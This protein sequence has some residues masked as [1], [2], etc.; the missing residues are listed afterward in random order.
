MSA[1]PWSRLAAPF[2]SAALA[3]HAVGASGDGTR[4][5]MSP[6]LPSVFLRERLD[7]VVGP[8]AWSLKL[9]PWSDGGIVAELTIAGATR[10][11]AVG[12]RPAPT[13][14]AAG[15]WIDVAAGAGEA[16]FAAAAAGF[17][18]L[19]PVEGSDDGWVDA[20]PDTGEPLFVPAT[21]PRTGGDGS[22]AAGADPGPAV[23]A[24]TLADDD[25]NG[26]DRADDPAVAAEVAPA[27]VRGNEPGEV[28]RE[29][30]GKPEAHRM[31]DRL[32]ERL[33]EEGLGAE[34]ARLVLSY[35]GYGKDQEHSRELYA[36][37]RAL[38]IGRGAH[39]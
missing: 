5:R 22:L 8:A 6:H 29:T 18:M 26:P 38:L 32:V 15:G 4:L 30:A 28:A 23:A 39:A 1:D 19:P 35:G 16:A 11:A 9:A 24:T 12:I 14:D 33:R 21:R 27:R 2:P 10:A 3:W 20:D 7:A 36:R 17:G 31:I 13:A 25:G 37:L 34:A